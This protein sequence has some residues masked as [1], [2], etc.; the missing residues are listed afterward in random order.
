MKNEYDYG[1]DYA[2]WGISEKQ[3]GFHAVD[4]PPDDYSLT[5]TKLS[6]LNTMTLLQFDRRIFLSTVDIPPDDVA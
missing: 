3:D 6:M 4:I 2:L 1:R 5:D